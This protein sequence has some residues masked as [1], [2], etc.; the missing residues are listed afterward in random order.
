MKHSI[1]LFD[2][3]GFGL[4]VGLRMFLI[5]CLLV[6][7]ILWYGQSA[8][9]RLAVSLSAVTTQIAD[10]LGL[11]NADRALPIARARFIR[12]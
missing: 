9:D 10:Q 3:P 5:P 1:G 12:P 6:S 8:R 2:D 7:A 11:G 4:L